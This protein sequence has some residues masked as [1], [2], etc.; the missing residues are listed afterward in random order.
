MDTDK[1]RIA[2]INPD[3]CKPKKCSL[4]C[5]KTCPVN[6]TGKVCIEVTKNSKIC[7]ISEVLCIGCGMC[8]KRC[9]FQAIQ[10]INLPK[11]L[12]NQVTHRYGANSFKLHRL[13]TPRSGEVLGL[14]GT[15][16]IG[17]STALRVLSGN[18][19]PNLG[20][21]ESP[22][23]WKEILKFFRGNELQNFFQKMLEDEMKALIKIQYVDS[24]AKSKAAKFVV[25][26]RL[27]NV[28]KRG[29]FDQAVDMLD[30]HAILE[31]EIGQL[32]GGELQRFIIGMTCVQAADIY[33]FDEPSSYLDVKQRLRAGRMIRSLL[34]PQT[35]VVVV[36][37]DLS[38]L[39][40]LS[41]YI[42]CLYGTPGAYGVVTMP[43][44][45]RQG[46]NCFLAGKVPSEN[47]RF[48]ETEL[49][50]KVTE[51]EEQKTLL[52]DESDASKD[53]KTEYH[54]PTMTKTLGPFKLSVEGGSFK[55]SE[56]V[57]M[58][59]QNGTGKTT[60]I[61]ML[62]GII[63]PDQE[64]VEMPRLS[65]S[66]KPQTIA[67]KFQGTVQ[68][69]LQA[70]LKES[71]ASSIFKTE[72]LIPL[73]IESLLD[74]EVQ[75]LSG[76][77]LQRVAIVLALAKPCDIFLIDEPSAYLDSEQR[78]VASKVMK[79]WICTSKRSAFIVEHDFIMATYLADKVICF[80]GIPAKESTCTSPEGLIT[81]MNKF[82]K[83]MEITFRRDP[84]NY[85]PRINKHGSQKD[86]EQKS[87]GNFF[88]MDDEKLSK[89]EEEEEKA[90][91]AAG[92]AAAK[93]AGGKGGKKGGKKD[94]DN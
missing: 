73:Q 20:N 60:L 56:I 38:I 77:E 13:P 64:D 57:M 21:F 53:N 12:E 74:N 15:N 26:Q 75:T 86:Q 19:K 80:E 30:L 55:P 83:M 49:T 36:E 43:M 14:V 10:I 35:Y 18:M 72:V 25:G 33:M 3:K 68:E 50:F 29:M 94:K 92:A 76:G 85:R 8:I 70:K 40:Y 6:K 11:G 52:K 27:K 58:L 22:P 59:G 23:D 79:R 90:M 46:I 32:S 91:A 66:Y 82:L 54:Y 39:D 65:I 17:K 87:A 1:L 28:D 81:G 42:C 88:L 61:K 9:P 62:A 48:R 31:R 84:T 78:V 4:E 89:E 71:W 69:L 47:M 45:V 5:S 37:H 7:F 67:P 44:S 93:A 34:Q 16:G 51:K 24:V 2:I 41:D 63:N